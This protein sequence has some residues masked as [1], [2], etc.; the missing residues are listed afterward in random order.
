MHGSNDTL[1]R[2]RVLGAGLAATVAAPLLGCATT[3]SG[4]SIGRVVVMD[5]TPD[6]S[7]VEGFNRVEKMRDP[8]HGHTHSLA[9]LRAM[10]ARLGLEA[11]ETHSHLAGPL[12]YGAILDISFPE[13]HTREELLELMR[14]DAVS[15]E[16]AL[17]FRAEM[18]GETVMVSYATSTVI[19]TKP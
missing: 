17:G 18:A 1:S 8:S 5:V 14:Q 2:R 11:G 9:E 15:G 13:E 16:D 6:E 19:W 4:P 12:P 10:G 3:G 7:K